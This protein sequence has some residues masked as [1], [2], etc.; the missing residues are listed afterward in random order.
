M[1]ASAKSSA[2]MGY[3][4]AILQ[5]VF[6][7]TMGIFGKVLNGTGMDAQS[8]VLLRFSC[9][10]VILGVFMLIWRKQPLVSRQPSVY[11]QAVFFFIS[12]TVYFFAVERLTAGMTTV[13]FYMYPVAVA[14][15]SLFAF[16]ERLSA[17]TLV[18]LVLSIAGLIFVSG[19]L[20]GDIVL[21]PL[22]IFLAIISCLAFAIYTVLIQKTGR[23]E[24]S[25]TVTFTLS[26]TSLL[27]SCVIFAPSVPGMF[28]IGL[29][30]VGIGCLM[31]LINTILPIVLYIAAVKHI[32]GTK[33]SLLGISE[34]PFSLVL[35]YLILGEQLTVL[36]GVGAAL[37]M[38][39]IVIITVA[40]LVRLRHKPPN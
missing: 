27:V 15:I 22:G 11:L 34:T 26:W 38:V 24:G 18:A 21:D 32:G 16:K 2:W 29:E 13:I 40:P 14:V 39:G 35:A 31:A 37:I 19:V 36:Q 20:G 4:A 10:T 5:A 9:T 17:S 23:T 25:F 28:A 33:A 3:V 6:Y 30:Q 1:T 8:V 12:S 7:S